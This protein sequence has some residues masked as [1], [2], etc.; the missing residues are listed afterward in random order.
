MY[1][2]QIRR[3]LV[4]DYRVLEAANGAE[5]LAVARE[6]M[7]DVVVS[8][9]LMPELDG[10]AMCRAIKAEPALEFIPVV[11]LTARAET[12]DKVEGL[13]CGADDYMTKP[14]DARELRARVANL[15][16]LRHRLKVRIEGQRNVTPFRPAPPGVDRAD[17][18]FLRRVQEAVES[19]LSD[20]EFGVEELAAALRMSRVHL[21]RR[22]REVCG[23]SPAELLMETRLESAARL[24]ADGAGSVSEVAYG[25]GFKSLSH[26]TRR[27]KGKYDES[28]SAFRAK[29]EDTGA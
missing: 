6:S 29:H 13:E 5:G 16:K 3:Y 17:S 23:Q 21:Y 15:I 7:P 25:V 28:P 10:R 19:G 11:L 12:E 18:R 1:K 2:R 14:F 24:L 22:L 26:F 4:E 27:F 9:V 8:D 20:D